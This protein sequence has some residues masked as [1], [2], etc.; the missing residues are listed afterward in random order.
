MPD[1][2]GVRNKPEDMEFIDQLNKIRY[3][4]SYGNIRIQLRAGKPTL[5]FIEKSIKLD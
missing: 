5:V 4:I 2:V 3:P 1:K